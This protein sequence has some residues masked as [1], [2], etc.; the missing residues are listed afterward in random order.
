MAN[1]NCEVCEQ[2]KARRQYP[3]GKLETEVR[4][5]NRRPCDSEA[6]IDWIRRNKKPARVGAEPYAPTYADFFLEIFNYGI[7]E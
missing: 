6:C 1:S 2:P 5:L 3:G 4:M 7:Y